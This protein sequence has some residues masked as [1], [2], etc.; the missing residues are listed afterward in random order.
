[1]VKRSAKRDATTSV[2]SIAVD[3]VLVVDMSTSV[4]VGTKDAAGF[5][6]DG[7]VTAAA[8]VEARYLVEVV[9]VN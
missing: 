4:G 5:L 9:I 1:M 7:V 2:T 6:V 3:T 8:I